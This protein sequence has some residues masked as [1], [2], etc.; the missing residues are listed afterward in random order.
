MKVD[1]PYITVETGD[2]S[3]WNQVSFKGT[4]FSRKKKSHVILVADGQG[5]DCGPHLSSCH[6]VF[7]WHFPCLWRTPVF[8]FWREKNSS[9]GG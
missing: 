3:E 4:L 6:A 2:C 7:A 9:G 1:L 8:R 5:C